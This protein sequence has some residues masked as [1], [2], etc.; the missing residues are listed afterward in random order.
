MTI[1][2]F[3]VD[4]VNKALRAL[5]GIANAKPWIVGTGV[6][7]ADDVEFGTSRQRAQPYM[8]PAVRHAEGKFD[9]FLAQAGSN[10]DAL[11]A[12]IR[13]IAFAVEGK[14]KEVVAVDTGNLK[15]SISAREA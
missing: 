1:R 4:E 9:T 2:S 15:N 3:G 5:K 10:P 7:Y 8:R 11:Q 6:E 12:L 13:L 14:A